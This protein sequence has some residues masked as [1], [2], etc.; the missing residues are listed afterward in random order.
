M[1]DQTCPNENFE[2]DQIPLLNEVRE[3]NNKRS[4]QSDR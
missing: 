4:N 2:A 1:K 3:Q